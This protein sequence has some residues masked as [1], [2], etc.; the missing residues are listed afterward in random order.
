MSTG[1]TPSSILT[2]STT[3]AFLG[4]P[5]TDADCKGDWGPC[6]FM[7]GTQAYAVSSPPIGN[8]KNCPNTTGDA[9]PCYSGY[10]DD[11]TKKFKSFISLNNFVYLVMILLAL[12]VFRYF[13]STLRDIFGGGRCT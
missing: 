7:T 10:M 5:I 1:A 3:T 12:T 6:N 13:I 2:P 8:G 9:R 11:A 4:A